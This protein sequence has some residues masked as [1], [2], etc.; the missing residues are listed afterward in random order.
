MFYSQ[1]GTDELEEATEEGYR[2]M[3]EIITAPRNITIPPGGVARY[4]Q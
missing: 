3:P 2:I 1:L 4:V